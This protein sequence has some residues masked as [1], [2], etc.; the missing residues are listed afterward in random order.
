MYVRRCRIKEI[1]F[2][3]NKLACHLHNVVRNFAAIRKR[4]ESLCSC[5]HF[6]RYPKRNATAHSEC[7]RYESFQCLCNILLVSQYNRLVN[8]FHRL[9]WLYCNLIECKPQRYVYLIELQHLV[10]L[11]HLI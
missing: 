10:Q 9:W 1:D 8:D 11:Q 6:G 5:T 2:N 7:C 3:F 4:D